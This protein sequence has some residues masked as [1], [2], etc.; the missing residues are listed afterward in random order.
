MTLPRVLVV[1]HEAGTGPG[2]WGDWL[3]ASG[4]ALEVRHPYA[5]EALPGPDDLGSYAALLVLGGAM[6]PVEDEACPWL[7]ATRGLLA[8]AV[9]AGLPTFGI[10]LGAE[11]LVVAC[12]G[13]VR[14]GTNGPELGVLTNDPTP[15]AADD[16]VLAS[17]RPG[18]RVLQWHWEELAELPDG[19]V[20]LATSPAYRHQAFRLG[21]AAWGVQGHPEV[22]P[23]ITA[24]WAREDSP[25]LLAAGRE[26]AGLV[27]E[28]EAATPELVATWRPV[29]EAFAAVVH[30]RVSSSGPLRLL[31]GDLAGRNAPVTGETG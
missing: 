7:P 10:C 29:A 16:P 23:G 20:L 4:L 17:L 11:L 28:V 14:R 12:G 6:G 25:L 19:A 18:A 31:D 15:E 21:T 1:Q 8:G 5:G 27:A 24:A 30:T 9:G 22:T 2:W 26:P 13:S 3:A